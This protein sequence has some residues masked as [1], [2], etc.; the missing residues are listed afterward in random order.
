MTVEIEQSNADNADDA[1]PL[2]GEIQTI[3]DGGDSPQGVK[4]K[5]D[6]GVTGYVQRVVD[7]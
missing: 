7:D 3:I 4:V 5:L 1:A 2:R 6:F